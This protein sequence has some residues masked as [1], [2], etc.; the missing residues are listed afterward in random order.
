MATS[1][2][3][4]ETETA[5]APEVTADNNDDEGYTSLM[6]DVSKM[7]ADYDPFNDPDVYTDEPYY[8]GALMS[9]DDIDSLAENGEDTAVMCIFCKNCTEFTADGIKCKAFPEGVPTEILNGFDHRKALGNE[10]TLFEAKDPKAYEEWQ[11]GIDTLSA[12]SGEAPAEAA[13]AETPAP[14]EGEAPAAAPA[15]TPAPE[16]AKKAVKAKPKVKPAPAPA[17]EPK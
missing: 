2:P 6:D 10:T 4:K 13:P 3:I 5:P 12:G 16:P 11:S 17:E 7:P 14:A 15:E 8:D 1:D 9:D